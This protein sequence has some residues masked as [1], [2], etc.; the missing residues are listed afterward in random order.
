MTD[1]WVTDPVLLARVL[2]SLRERETPG[3]PWEVRGS[4]K[5]AVGPNRVIRRPM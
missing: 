4:V 5:P 3:A 2:T 1:N